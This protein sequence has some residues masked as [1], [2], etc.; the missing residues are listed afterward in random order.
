MTSQ[1]LSV[2]AQT[3]CVPSPEYHQIIQTYRSNLQSF[4]QESL[5]HAQRHLA[6]LKNDAD[7][8]QAELGRTRVRI[9]EEAQQLESGLSL[10]VSL[11]KKR[12][13]EAAEEMEVRALSVS[14]YVGERVK[15]IEEGLVQ[16]SKHARIAI[17]GTLI[18]F[19][20]H[21]RL[22]RNNIIAFDFLQ[23]ASHRE[24]LI[25]LYNFYLDLTIM[26]L[27]PRIINQFDEV[28]ESECKPQILKLFT[29]GEQIAFGAPLYK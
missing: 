28:W 11:E 22:C 10:D 13:G 26:S 27:L 19:C 25:C 7:F 9:G 8:I 24:G 5:S 12:R 1:R 17:A 4:H 21:F 3:K 18:I 23:I 16:V 14:A 29:P 6:S 15:E 20:L 2:D